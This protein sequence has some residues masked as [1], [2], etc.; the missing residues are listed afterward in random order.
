MTQLRTQRYIM[1]LSSYPNCTLRQKATKKGR[2][3]E[4]MQR[5]EQKRAE[6]SVTNR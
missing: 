4:D 2:D 6:F 5:N 1:A 3:T